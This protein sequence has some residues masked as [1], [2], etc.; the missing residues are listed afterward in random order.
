MKKIICIA[1]IILSVIMAFSCTDE[2]SYQKI[3]AQRAK[4]IMDTNEDVI[5]LDVRT[6][7]E[8]NEGHIEGAMLI[9]DY[10]ILTQAEGKLPDKEKIILVYCRTGNRSK[11]T[12]KDLISLGYKNVYDFGG[13]NSW[14][15][16]LV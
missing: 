9:P 11:R 3:S 10:N 13:I 6:Q 16:G 15:Y 4:E 1:I 2:T 14:S 7:S 12:S 8:Y 5:I